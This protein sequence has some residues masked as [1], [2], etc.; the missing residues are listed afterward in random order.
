MGSQLT[1]FN[2]ICTCCKATDTFDSNTPLGVASRSAQQV[3]PHA[4]GITSLDEKTILLLMSMDVTNISPNASQHNLLRIRN[5][6]NR[7][8]TY[9][10]THVDPSPKKYTHD[11]QEMLI[12]SNPRLSQ[13]SIITDPNILKQ[14][15]ESNYKV[16]ANEHTPIV[17]P[18]QHEGQLYRQGSTTSAADVDKLSHEMNAQLISL[19]TASNANKQNGTSV[20]PSTKQTI[21]REH[22][23]KAIEQKHTPT[24]NL[25][26]DGSEEKWS[27]PQME[28]MRIAMKKELFHLASEAVSTSFNS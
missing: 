19:M 17:S 16:F 3:Q 14:K 15:I 28:D 23:S 18:P 2:R 22:I 9:P 10:S 21:A 1:K 24:T 27:T 25:L 13:M 7:S 4:E 26:R 11:E 6:L 20:H 8:H 5:R 12:D